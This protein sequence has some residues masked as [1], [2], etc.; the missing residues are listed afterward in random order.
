MSMNAA[1]K[2]EDLVP[3]PR[4]AGDPEAE[5][6]QRLAQAVELL[7]HEQIEEAEQALSGVLR[8]QPGQPDALHFLG[9]VRHAQGRSDE[10]VLLIRTALAHVPEHGGA[11]NNLGNVLLSAGRIDEATDAYERGV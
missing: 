9:V 7:R 3:P 2:P 6:A 11:W 8:D 10:A 4:A 5:V 1:Y